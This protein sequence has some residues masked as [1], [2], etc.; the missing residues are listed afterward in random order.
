M[1][2]FL[3][4]IELVHRIVEGGIEFL[5]VLGTGFGQ[6]ADHDHGDGGA[7]HADG[8]VPGAA[9][10]PDKVGHKDQNGAHHGRY[11]GGLFGGALPVDGA[12][13]NGEQGHDDGDGEHDQG[14]DQ[15]G[16][17]DGQQDADSADDRDGRTD[18]DHALR[19]IQLDAEGMVQ[20]ILVDDGAGHQQEGVGGGDAHG[21][22]ADEE[23]DHQDHGQ[24]GVDGLDDI[25]DHIRD[26]QLGI[27][28]GQAGQQGDTNQTDDHGAGP[29]HS[30][31]DGGQHHQLALSA[32]ILAGIAGADKH[33]G[34]HDGPADGAGE[35]VAQASAVGHP[36][37][38]TGVG[39]PFAAVIPDGVKRVGQ[40]AVKAHDQAGNGDDPEQAD[41][42]Q[43]LN[44]IGGSHRLHAAQTDVNDD[45]DADDHDDGAVI[46]LT[47][48]GDLSGLTDGDQNR[49]N[50]GEGR[51]QK[52]QCQN[53]TQGGA[54]EPV[55][56][57]IGRSG[58]APCMVEQPHLVHGEVG[59]DGEQDDVAQLRHPVTQSAAVIAAGAGEEDPGA[60][61]GGQIG[62]DQN[63]PFQGAA[64][65]QEGAGR[66]GAASAAFKDR[67]ADEK[68]QIGCEGDPDHILFQHGG[69]LT[70]SD[71]TC[72]VP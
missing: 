18:Q 5:A 25:L 51:Y 37:V 64:C 71:G 8:A 29:D 62:H 1:V 38:G 23:G 72:A 40:G 10:V 28:R 56:V 59:D 55:V 9:D 33:V 12:H 61:Q 13:Q 36:A 20:Q 39:E 45:G 65:G 63:G 24:S 57:E 44:G 35:G 22:C 14:V 68:K 43:T 49:G 48:G 34:Q 26:D 67:D 54:A 66:I 7:Q 42:Q 2:S 3:D 60:H 21:G 15:L 31:Q 4:G 27:G 41:E 6:Q 58:V 70:S 53:H 69:T 52:Y 17:I 46:G 32:H 47:A 30:L 16:R 50:V 11:D 19:F